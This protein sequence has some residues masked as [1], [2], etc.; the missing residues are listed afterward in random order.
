[1]FTCELD[2]SWSFFLRV[3]KLESFLKLSKKNVA[4]FSNGWYD[5][6]SSVGCCW[7]VELSYRRCRM[8]IIL[9]RLL[10][11]YWRWCRRT[12]NTVNCS[13]NSIKMFVIISCQLRHRQDENIFKSQGAV[14]FGMESDGM[15]I[16]Y[17][18]VETRAQHGH[19]GESHATSMNIVGG[20]I[21]Y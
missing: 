14:F 9:L 20:E 10:V 2:N 18:T 21:N 13:S 16:F 15:R 6:S 11:E 4:S 1:M 5:A 12:K 7:W 19:V 8:I 17:S 3:K